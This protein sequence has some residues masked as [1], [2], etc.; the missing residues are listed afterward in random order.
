LRRP[1]QATAIYQGDL[2]EDLTSLWI[3]A[4]REAARRQVLDALSALVQKGPR[5]NLARVINLLE[6]VRRRDLY[7]ES[8]YRDLIRAQAAL[9]QVEAARRTFSL[10]TKVMKE[11]NDRP[12]DET[13]TLVASLQGVASPPASAVAS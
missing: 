13:V 12:S 10:L 6:K 7:N 2:A 9:G 8:I 4:P 11:L 3:E 5:T 1:E